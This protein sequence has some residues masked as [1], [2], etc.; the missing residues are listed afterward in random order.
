[1]DITINDIPNRLERL[2]QGLRDKV[3]A[4]IDELE[5][6]AGHMATDI[7]ET[8]KS[9]WAEFAEELS[10][11]APLTGLGDEFLKNSKEF[12]EGFEFKLER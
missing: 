2:P 5:R 1:M 11:K 7:S 9:K 8:K 10:E 3:F 4:F 6:Q 12:R